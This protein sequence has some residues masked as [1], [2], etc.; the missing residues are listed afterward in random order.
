MVRQGLY[1]SLFTNQVEGAL[2]EDIRYGTNSGLVFGSESFVVK[3]EAL[4]GRRLREGLKGKSKK[5]VH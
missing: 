2:L 1:R 3:L 5:N 4:C